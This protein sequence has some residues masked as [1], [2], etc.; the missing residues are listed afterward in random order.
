[1]SHTTARNLALMAALLSGLPAAAMAQGDI[2][3]V[4]EVTSQDE[5]GALAGSFIISG[6]GADLQRG[7]YMNYGTG[8]G[9]FPNPL[10]PQTVENFAHESLLTLAQL[11]ADNTPDLRL[12]RRP[13]TAVASARTGSPP[14][15]GLPATPLR[16][17]RSRSSRTRN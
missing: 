4:V 6:P 8:P 3:Q 9:D 15:W 16:T 13:P 5:T 10:V 17:A 11:R 1:M 14:A 7:V 2:N 12:A